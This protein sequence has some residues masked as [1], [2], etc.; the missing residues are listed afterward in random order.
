[1]SPIANGRSLTVTA[2][3]PSSRPNG[4]AAGSTTGRLNVNVCGVRR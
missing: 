1:V 3:R 2:S 4:G